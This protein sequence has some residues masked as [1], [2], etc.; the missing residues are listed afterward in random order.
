V[1][2]APDPL[3]ITPAEEADLPLVLRFIR[4]LADYERL[5]HEVVAT[6]ERLRRT[7]FGDDPAAEVLVARWEGEPV[8]FALFFRSYSTFLALPGIYLEDLFVLPEARGRGIGEAL[9]RRLAALTV[10]RGFGRLEWS[11]LDWNEPALRFY[12]R[13]GAIPME[14]WTVHRV[15]G[16]TLNR[17]A[18]GGGG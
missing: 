16:E 15:T 10:E 14:G 9:L 8:G 7:L 12:R 11:V 3:E 2:A 6:E 4:G 13:M 5:A 1:S 18:E 17:M